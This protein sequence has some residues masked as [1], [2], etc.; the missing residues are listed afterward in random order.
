MSSKDRSRCLSLQ[1][2]LVFFSREQDTLNSNP[3]RDIPRTKEPVLA[4]CR[5]LKLVRCGFYQVGQIDC[6]DSMCIHTIGEY[7]PVMA[8]CMCHVSLLELAIPHGCSENQA[9]WL[10]PHQTLYTT[11]FPHHYLRK[12]NVLFVFS[13]FLL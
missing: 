12:M 6:A 2:H 8:S 5:V 9:L 13:F 10:Q 4:C 1:L 11:M 7:H 3:P